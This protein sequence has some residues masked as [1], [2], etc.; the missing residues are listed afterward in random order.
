MRSIQT[1]LGFLALCLAVAGCSRGYDG[2]RRFSLSGKVTV[3][4]QP[5]DS[6]NISFI[7]KSGDRQR[8]SGGPIVDGTYSVLEE[9]G[10]N[11]GSYR[12]EIRWQK[13]TGKKYKDPDSGEMFDV[14]KEGLPARYHSKSELTAD[15]SDD[16]TTFDFEL[17]SN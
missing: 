15:V 2:D 4:G 6:G 5:L 11:A 16:K 7:P 9:S 10:A 8:V 13:A 3:D 14:R 17:K 1:M 12:V